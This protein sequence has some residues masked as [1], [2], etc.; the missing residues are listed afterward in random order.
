[1]DLAALG[2]LITATAS[3][4]VA[5]F[6]MVTAGKAKEVAARVEE[7]AKQSEQVRAHATRAGD[8]IL[9]TSADIIIAA[10]TVQFFLARR[11]KKTLDERE[12]L[13]L[14][15]PMTD[16]VHK[17]RQVMYSTEIYTTEEIRNDV[18]KLLQSF[19][20]GNVEFED[21]DEFVEDLK[22]QHSKIATSFRKAYLSS[23]LR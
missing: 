11:A 22:K 20:A 12:V 4:G 19:V 1:M 15:K 18:S 7:S 10:E 23:V 21:W 3:L 16:P 6:S 8:E 9:S 13:E 2:A 17:M 14:F 5:V